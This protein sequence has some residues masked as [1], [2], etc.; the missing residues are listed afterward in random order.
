MTVS[1]H[2]L[3]PSPGSMSGELFSSTGGEGVPRPTCPASPRARPRPAQHGRRRGP[4]GLSRRSANSG[5]WGGAG[6]YLQREWKLLEVV[7]TVTSSSLCNTASG[8]AVVWPAGGGPRLCCVSGTLCG[9]PADGP[10]RAC[11]SLHVHAACLRSRW[12]SHTR[13][14]TACNSECVWCASPWFAQ[15]EGKTAPRP[16]TDTRECGL[17]GV[18]EKG[19]WAP[20]GFPPLGTLP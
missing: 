4:P 2:H 14:F 17:L 8:C 11:P 19:G 1:C 12:A 10:R 7:A 18:C 6:V 9:Q 20:S 5:G 16:G 3:T 13:G 15:G